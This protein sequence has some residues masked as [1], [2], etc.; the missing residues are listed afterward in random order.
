MKNIRKYIRKAAASFLIQ[1]NYNT[2]FFLFYLFFMNNI[3][4]FAKEYIS[5]DL[6]IIALTK[7]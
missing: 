1:V 4:I 6:S 5:F 3:L 7:G 2:I